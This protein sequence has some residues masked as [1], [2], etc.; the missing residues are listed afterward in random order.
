MDL[1]FLGL[2]DLTWPW[3]Q[4]RA[5]L[6]RERADMLVILE[7]AS[8]DSEAALVTTRVKGV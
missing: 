5:G 6:L 7:V 1:L 3:L 2:S 8:E 4:E